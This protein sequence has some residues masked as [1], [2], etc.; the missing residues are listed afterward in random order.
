MV[1]R[2]PAGILERVTENSDYVDNS[3]LPRVVVLIACN[4]ATWVKAFDYC[5]CER[6]EFVTL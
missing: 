5:D 1:R 6:D 2:D 3:H 4:E